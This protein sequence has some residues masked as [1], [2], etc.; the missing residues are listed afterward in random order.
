MFFSRK[1]GLT[2]DEILGNLE[3]LEDDDPVAG[4]D[5]VLFP[6]EDEAATDEDSDD[7]DELTRDPNRLGKGILSQQAEVVAHGDDEELPDLE[8]VR[9]LKI[10]L[11][12]SVFFCELLCVALMRLFCSAISNFFSSLVKSEN[13]WYRYDSVYI[14]HKQRSMWFTC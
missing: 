1:V 7:E 13:Q 3:T 6:P 14:V 12:V 2:T 9:K 4:Y 10:F 8:T 5:I 11:F